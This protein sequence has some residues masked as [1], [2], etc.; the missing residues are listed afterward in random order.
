M[1]PPF[2]CF[3]G[4]QFSSGKAMGGHKKV[5]SQKLRRSS[6]D[7]DGPRKKKNPIPNLNNLKGGAVISARTENGKPNVPPKKRKV[8][9]EDGDEKN[10]QSTAAGERYFCGVCGVYFKSHR[11]LAAHSGHH[12][13]AAR[14]MLSSKVDESS[15]SSSSSSDD[16]HDDEDYDVNEDSDSDSEEEAESE[17]EKRMAF[18]CPYDCER[19]FR[20][21]KALGGH[22]RH[23]RNRA[24]AAG[25]AGGHG[26][27]A[28]G[29]RR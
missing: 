19:V 8:I 1:E 7:D 24:A 20:S 17:A 21:G 16:D 12:T 10:S 28:A 25:V 13:K 4:K 2:F 14:K 23:C 6:E 18:K 27:E 26:R 9:M 29:G 11:S 5:H 3:C 22:K 15:S